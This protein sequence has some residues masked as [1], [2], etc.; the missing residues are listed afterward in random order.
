MDIAVFIDVASGMIHGVAAVESSSGIEAVAEVQAF[1]D[2]EA[3][4]ATATGGHGAGVEN[5]G[6]IAA[7]HDLVEALDGCFEKA[8]D[9]VRAGEL[10]ERTQDLR[11][12]ER[13]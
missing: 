13:V 10:E 7:V 8:V 5:S 6:G 2:I 12:G 11:R 1:E 3:G 9:V 4:P